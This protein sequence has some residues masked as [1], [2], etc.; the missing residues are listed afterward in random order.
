MVEHLEHSPELNEVQTHEQ[1]V[2]LDDRAGKRSERFASRER[3]SD[4]M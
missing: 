2:H 3:D 4:L 1:P